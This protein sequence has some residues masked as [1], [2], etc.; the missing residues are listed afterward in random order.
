MEQADI[1]IIKKRSKDLL[2]QTII[3]AHEGMPSFIR[4]Y[5]TIAG[6]P[7]YAGL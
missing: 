6:Y 1:N 5:A 3:A 4:V 2:M 7:V